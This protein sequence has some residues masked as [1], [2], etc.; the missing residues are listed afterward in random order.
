MEAHKHLNV[1]T[2]T[3]HANLLGATSARSPNTKMRP[4]SSRAAGDREV[5]AIWNDAKTGR[6]VQG[7]HRLREPQR[8][9]AGGHQDFPQ[10][11]AQAL[12]A[13]SRRPAVPHAGSPLHAGL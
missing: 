6:E 2:E 10:R 3:E 13:A 9:A 12:E 8:R 7:P 11:E 5:V 4:R 1:L